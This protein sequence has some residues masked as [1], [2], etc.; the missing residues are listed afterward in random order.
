MR[1]LDPMTFDISLQ[2]RIDLSF[3]SYPPGTYVAPG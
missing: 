3:R 2:N 1:I